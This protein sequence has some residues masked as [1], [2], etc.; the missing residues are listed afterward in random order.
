MQ[1]IMGMRWCGQSNQYSCLCARTLHIAGLAAQ[2]GFPVGLSGEPMAQRLG[3][4]LAGVDGGQFGTDMYNWDALGVND[5]AHGPFIAAAASI[6]CHL[7]LRQC[8]P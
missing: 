4:E 5:G 6:R 2:L 8:E 1:F 7:R 3:G